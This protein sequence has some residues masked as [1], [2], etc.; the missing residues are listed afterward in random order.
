M[1]DICWFTQQK[2]GRGHF[3]AERTQEPKS[4]PQTLASLYF[5]ALSFLDIGF[6]MRLYLVDPEVHI[7]L[8]LVRKSSTD[9][10]SLS[11]PWF[12]WSLMHHTV[13]SLIWDW[14]LGGS[15]VS[16][17]RELSTQAKPVSLSQCVISPAVCLFFLLFCPTLWLKTSQ[18]NC[19]SPCLG[20]RETR[21][22]WKPCSPFFLT[23]VL[24]SLLT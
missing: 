18:S 22:L 2:S 7:N 13:V 24:L 19:T 3:Q 16:R 14:T 10:W 23:G 21:I 4:C 1:N 20:D 8:F 15:W 11:S 6:T 12:P 17:K 9:R 5:S